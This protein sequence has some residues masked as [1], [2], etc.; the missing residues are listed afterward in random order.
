VYIPVASGREEKKS[1][2]PFI[3][4]AIGVACTLCI[5]GVVLIATAPS[6]NSDSAETAESGTSRWSFNF[7]GINIKIGSDIYTLEDRGGKT[8]LETTQMTHYAALIV[9]REALCLDRSLPCPEIQKD[10]TCVSRGYPFAFEVDAS[11]PN[12]LRSL[13]SGVTAWVREKQAAPFSLEKAIEDKLRLDNIAKAILAA[14]EVQQAI[15]QAENVVQQAA[16]NLHDRVNTA[17]ADLTR[18]VELLAAQAGAFVEEVAHENLGRVTGTLAS[19]EE[20]LR[21]GVF[22]FEDAAGACVETSI[23]YAGIWGFRKSVCADESKCNPIRHGVTCAAR[24][25]SQYWDYT[26]N[27]SDPI[28]IALASVTGW[29][30]PPTQNFL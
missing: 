22:T 7:G 15:A 27:L 12:F 4:G 23:N 25:Y 3:L 17:G 30:L 16:N 6:S 2:T 10:R 29:A 9:I 24:G 21:G 1:K 5:V 13:T 18:Q 26:K 11:T 20:H 8:C 14:P 19:V 28:K